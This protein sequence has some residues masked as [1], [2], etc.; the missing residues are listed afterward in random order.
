MVDQGIDHDAGVP[1]ADTPVVRQWTTFA[2]RNSGSF[3]GVKRTRFVASGL[4]L[5]CHFS[6]ELVDSTRPKPRH[7]RHLADGETPGEFVPGARD[8][9]GLRPWPTEASPDDAR[10]GGEVPIALDPGLDGTKPSIHT[11]ADHAALELG[12]GARHVEE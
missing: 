12:K 10:L 2:N 3:M 4:R 7:A 9:L 5:G 1:V 11:L 8:L 6:L